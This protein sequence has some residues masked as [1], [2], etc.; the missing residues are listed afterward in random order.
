MSN[1]F[2]LTRVMKLIEIERPVCVVLLDTNVIIDY[3]FPDIWE[4]NAGPAIFIIPDGILIELEFLRERTGKSSPNSLSISEK[5]IQAIKNITGLFCKGKIAEGIKIPGGWAITTPSP[6]Q[7]NLKTELDQIQDIVKAFKPSDSKYLLLTKE[8]DEQLP[9][10]VIMTTGEYNLFCIAQANGIPFRLI[11]GFPMDT[12]IEV[13]EDVKEWTKSLKGMNST[14]KQIS[15]EVEL[16]LLTQKSAPDYFMDGNKKVKISEGQGIVKDRGI[17]RPFLWIVTFNEMEFYQTAEE[18]EKH[19][20]NLPMV[21]LDSIAE[22]GGCEQ[23]LFD[24]IA[25]RLSDCVNPSPLAGPI[26]LLSPESIMRLLLIGLYKNEGKPIDKLIDEM[27]IDYLESEWLDFTVN[28]DDSEELIGIFQQFREATMRYWGI[29]ET[30][31]FRNMINM[32]KTTE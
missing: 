13:E 29:G 14:T 25:D 7:D 17:N 22:G 12:P 18:A 23:E 2:D 8:C 10:P 1:I 26:T 4:M 5:A 28:K 6:K 31:K 27:D 24:A 20:Q 30:Y 15:L 9:T 32:N 11:N 3:P 21:Y 19:F 16:T